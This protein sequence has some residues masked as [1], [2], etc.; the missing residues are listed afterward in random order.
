MIA[1][2]TNEEALVAAIVHSVEISR[3]PEDVFAC[4]NDFS[5]FGEWQEGLVSARL[6]G[7]GPVKVGSRVTQT[8]RIGRGERTMTTEVTEYSPPRSYAFRGIDG[9]IRAMGKGTVEPLDNG[10]RSRVTFE[11]DFQ[12]HGFGK[13]LLPL[14]RSQARKQLAT[15]HQ[16]LKERLESGAA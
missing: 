7:D 9:P 5:R 4:L 6:E 11:L 15:T 3:S 16:R 14:V 13:L 8:R 1:L 2:V 10:A 12:G